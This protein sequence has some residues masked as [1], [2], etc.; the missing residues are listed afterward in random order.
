MW[1]RNQRCRGVRVSPASGATVDRR[2][3]RVASAIAAQGFVLAQDEDARGDDVMTA[4]PQGAKQREVRSS[5]QVDV[6][7]VSGERVAARGGQLAV[8]KGL[9]DPWISA[10]RCAAIAVAPPVVVLEIEDRAGGYD[11]DAEPIV[12]ALVSLRVILADHS[13]LITRLR[14]ARRKMLGERSRHSGLSQPT[15]TVSPWT[16]LGIGWRLMSRFPVAV[17]GTD[18]VARPR[19]G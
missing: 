16:R 8:E 3:I 2:D 7:P 15:T 4:V 10:D 14:H 9:D 13:D 19:H 11:A 17:A 5:R 1:A 18:R 12:A 6:F